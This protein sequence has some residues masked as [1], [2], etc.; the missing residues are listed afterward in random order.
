MMPGGGRLAGIGGKPYKLKVGEA[1][2]INNQK[3]HSVMNKG[4]EEIDLKEAVYMYYPFT[5]IAARG[6][7]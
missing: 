3:T 4:R 5:T 6:N 1:Y 2:E 7:A